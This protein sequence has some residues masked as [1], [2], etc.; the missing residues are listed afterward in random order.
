MN[1]PD[2][3]NAVGPHNH[4]QLED[5]WLKLAR[6]EPI[7]V[8]VL[9]GAGTA[10]CAGGDVKKMAERAQTDMACN[11]RCACRRTRCASGSI[12]CFARNRS[13]Q[14]SMATPSALALRSSS[15]AT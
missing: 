13:S 7:K 11:T 4:W 12:C 1:D 8:I 15:S 9:T 10:F 5:I 6:D 2:K 3:L 14:R